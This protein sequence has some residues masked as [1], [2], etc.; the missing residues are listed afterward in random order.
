MILP[1]LKLNENNQPV[2]NG[3]MDVCSIEEFDF[4]L[5]TSQ[6]I[7]V[8]TVNFDEEFW[9]NFQQKLIHIVSAK[10]MK[11][12]LQMENQNLSI[13]EASMIL[14]CLKLNKNN[15]PVL[16]VKVKYNTQIQGQMDVCSIE[17]CEH[18][19]IFLWRQFILMTNFWGNFQ[20]KLIH[21]TENM[22]PQKMYIKQ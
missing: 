14:P 6:D 19:R 13:K 2:L 15:E 3:Q 17:E 16:N 7:F 21:F 4:V 8:E 11:F 12:G 10:S 22:W 5:C 1:C 18:H 20:Q 9:G